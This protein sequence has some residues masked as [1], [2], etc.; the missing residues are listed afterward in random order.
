MRLRTKLLTLQKRRSGLSLNG[1]AHFEHVA[2]TF[3]I[4]EQLSFPSIKACP[5]QE[6]EICK[7]RKGGPPPAAPGHLHLFII[8]ALRKEQRGVCTW[9]PPTPI[10]GGSRG[11][12]AERCPH[13]GYPQANP[14]Y[15]G[16]LLQM[17][18]ENDGQGPLQNHTSPPPQKK[19]EILFP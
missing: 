17:A 4:T 16:S 2:A 18:S 12:R 11:P 19:R 8:S 14:F 10:K 15:K 1:R 6:M 3:C 9:C 5:P 7:A 13:L